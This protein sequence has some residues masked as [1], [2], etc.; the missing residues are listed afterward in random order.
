MRPGDIVA[1]DTFLSNDM[2]REDQQELQRE[3]QFHAHTKDWPKARMVQYGKELQ[4]VMASFDRLEE[5]WG[6]E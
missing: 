5:E 6:E 2:L 3:L 4:K 1:C